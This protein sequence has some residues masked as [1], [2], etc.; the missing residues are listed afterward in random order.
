[1]GIKP[2]HGLVPNTGVF[3]LSSLRDVVGPIARCVRD[4]ALTLDALA[5]FSMEDPKTLAGVDK[6]PKGGY[7]SKLDKNALKAS[8]LVSMGRAGAPRRFP[9]RRQAFISAPKK[10]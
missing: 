4:A 1:M 3:P 9:R 2:T 8:A 10:N 5:G 6:R 7:I